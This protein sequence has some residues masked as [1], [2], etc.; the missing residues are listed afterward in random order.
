M[1]MN[2][3]SR[4]PHHPR[5]LAV[6][7]ALTAILVLSP[8][9][10]AA[11]G[12]APR[13]Q[14]DKAAEAAPAARQMRAVTPSMAYTVSRSVEPTGTEVREFVNAGQ[15]V[16]AVVWQGPVLPDLAAYFGD[17]YP[18]Y[19]Q[20]VARKRA[21]GQRGGVVHARTAELVMVSRGRMGHFEGYAYLPALVPNGVNIQSLLP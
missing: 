19:G 11:L 14:A 4:A 15:Q 3:H 1:T 12:G 20:A 16:F 6:V 2:P 5:W 9:A 8:D 21:A 10:Q 18:A 17:H 13:A 7:G